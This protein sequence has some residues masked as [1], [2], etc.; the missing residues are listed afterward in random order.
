MPPVELKIKEPLY[1]IIKEKSFDDFTVTQLR[2][3][4]L[5]VVENELSEKDARILV[6][7]QILRLTKKG[8]LSKSN[9]S[10]GSRD[11]IYSKTAL[12]HEVEIIHSGEYMNTDTTRISENQCMNLE[13]KSANDDVVNNLKEQVKGD[14]VDLISSISESEEY[15]R[16]IKT[17]PQ[18]K[19]YLYSKY[20]D[21]SER[22]SKY[23]GR[24]RAAKNLL[25]H[26][27]EE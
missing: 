6:Y 15:L 7:K 27:S 20:F 8:L 24:I 10:K 22:S 26:L 21:V 9:T 14:K 12:F 25:H 23:I 4:F 11:A 5:K 16:L 17:F 3:V 1:S 18:A 13:I 2:E 19:E